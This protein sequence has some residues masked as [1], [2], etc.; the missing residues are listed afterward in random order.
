[1]LIPC[2][3]RVVC[4]YK[5]AV[6]GVMSARSC[7]KDTTI[8]A[9]QRSCLLTFMSRMKLVGVVVIPGLGRSGLFMKVRQSQALNDFLAT[10]NFI[11]E[12][13]YLF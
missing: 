6:I 5:Q 12:H 4:S 9:R 8:S 3:A 7:R 11:E 10:L 1:M 2:V 13:N